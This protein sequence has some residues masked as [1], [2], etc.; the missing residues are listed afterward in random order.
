MGKHQFRVTFENQNGSVTVAQRGRGGGDAGD[1]SEKVRNDTDSG[2]QNSIEQLVGNAEQL[3][4]ALEVFDYRDLD[5]GYCFFLP[6][7]SCC[8]SLDIIPTGPKIF[9]TKLKALER[10]QVEFGR[11]RLSTLTGRGRGRARLRQV[12]D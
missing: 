9:R 3:L 1:K 6:L 5:L 8:S 2:K 7:H 12:G 4:Q 10:L 11:G